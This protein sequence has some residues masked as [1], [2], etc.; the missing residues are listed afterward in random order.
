[1]VSPRLLLFEMA[2]PQ[3][4]IPGQ[5]CLWAEQTDETNLE[6]LMWPRAAA[7]AELFW[8]GAG[9]TGFPKSK[10]LKFA[11]MPAVLT[12]RLDGR[13]A[14]DARYQVPYGGPRREGD[15]TSAPLVCDSSWFV[16]TRP[17][18]DLVADQ[19]RQVQS[20]SAVRIPVGSLC[21]LHTAMVMIVRGVIIRT[22]LYCKI[23][24]VQDVGCCTANMR[25]G[26]WM[27]YMVYA[28]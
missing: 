10:P 26:V 25:L 23:V 17:K 4:M 13:V 22:I 16:L 9:S 7:V 12:C 11:I 27:D 5:A 28:T 2:E 1:M 21:I 15:A 6:P 3:L 14:E 8:S 24:S 18:R 20:R 19:G